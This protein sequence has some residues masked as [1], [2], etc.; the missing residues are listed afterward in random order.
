[1]ARI[2]KA[3]KNNL[4]TWYKVVGEISL[5]ELAQTGLPQEDDLFNLDSLSFSTGFSRGFF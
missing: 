1:M 3:N 5:N 2:K 4:L